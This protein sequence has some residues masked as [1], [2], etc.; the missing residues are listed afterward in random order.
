MFLF[1]R[2]DFVALVGLWVQAFVAWVFVAILGALRR[3]EQPSA[4]LESFF[5]AFVALAASLS[6]LSIRFFTAHDIKPD[7]R[8]ADGQPGVTACYCAYLG[9][10]AAFG[11]YIVRG[12]YELTGRQPSAR[13]ERLWW[14]TIALL[15]LAPIAVPDITPLLMVQA[16]AMIAAAAVS[17]HV[18]RREDAEA[19]GQTLVRLSLRAL[20][21]T[22]T[23]HGVVA[24]TYTLA[25]WL[26]FL[27][28]F[29]S[30]FDL[31][32]QLMLGVGLVIGVLHESHRR[33]R[34]AEIER[35]RLERELARNEKL[36]ALGTLVSGVAHELNNPLTVILG[37]AE[38]LGETPEVAGQARIISEQA[39]RCRGVVRSLSALAGQ[40]K[41][42]PEQLDTREL[43]ERVVR[44]LESHERARHKTIAIEAAAGLVVHADRIGLE[45]VLSNL[46][47][48]ALDA[49]PLNGLVTIAARAVGER[50]EFSVND[51]GPGVPDGLRARL[52]EPFF[53]TKNPGAGL[54]LGLAIAHA[55]VRAH[56]GTISVEPGRDN[57]GARFVV[58]LPRGEAR[59]NAPA[60]T[61]R[62]TLAGRRL[63]VLDDD[64]GVRSVLR[65]HAERRGWLVE[66]AHCAEEALADPQR[67][68]RADVVLC[69]LRMPG[70][71]GIGFHDRLAGER[72]DLLARTVFATGDLASAEAVRFSRRCTRPLI[73]KP[74]DFGALF[75]ALE[76]AVAAR[77]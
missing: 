4:A 76:S 22:W 75:A 16:P 53:T 49:S 17:L 60:P 33:M 71:G 43:I 1:D 48:N 59:S 19:S 29:N 67:L 36:R 14:P 32:V 61:Q 56:G 46:L 35:E 39:E 27:L 6:V 8:W 62:T 37:Y 69:D 72:T 40:S 64:D 21:V 30:L 42:S 68:V 20:L 18:L 23:V 77:T 65:Q 31:A 66:E 44:G 52:F 34:A 41:Q 38:I 63:L 5:R 73:Q 54:G 15:A 26:R 45:Q 24:A 10:K 47:S 3:R 7:V 58:V 28:S 2:I 12:C 25:P 74:F 13:L 57:R 51:Q 11:L 55:I 9:L 70:M 50:V